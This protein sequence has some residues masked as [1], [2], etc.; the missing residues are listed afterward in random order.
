MDD[1]NVLRTDQENLVKTINS[2]QRAE[3]VCSGLSR[4]RLGGDGGN[5]DADF[6]KEAVIEVARPCD[7][8]TRYT[9]TVVDTEEAVD[10]ERMTF[11]A[12]VVPF[13]K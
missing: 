7:T 10:I 1:S 5:G 9:I 4:N 2:M 3:V 11:A 13:G 6:E 12:F 8:S